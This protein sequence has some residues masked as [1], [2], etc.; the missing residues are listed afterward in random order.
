VD[1]NGLGLC[2]GFERPCIY[3]SELVQRPESDGSTSYAVELYRPYPA[4]GDPD[5][6]QLAIEDPNETVDV[7]SFT[8]T[9]DFWVYW[10]N[11]RASPVFS[12]TGKVH[13]RRPVVHNSITTMVTVDSVNVPGGAW[14]SYQRDINTHRCMNRKWT[15]AAASTVGAANTYSSGTKPIQAHPANIDFTNVG[16]IGKVFSESAYPPNG[17][18]YSTDIDEEEE[19]RIDLSDPNYQRLFNYLTVF[20][21]SNDGIDNDG[22]GLTDEADPN[23]PQETPEFKIPGRININTAPWYIIAQL[24][25]VSQRTG[26]PNDYSLA[27]AIAAYRDK[28]DL[29]G[30]GG[31][32]YRLRPGGPGFRCTGELNNVV[33]GPDPYRIDYYALDGADQIQL[34][35]LTGADGAA[36]DFE[37]RDLI[38]A[39]ISNLVTARSD[40]FTAYILVRIGTDGP[41]RRMIA[42]LDRSNVY[43]SAGKVNVVALHPVPDPR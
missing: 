25:W 1:V 31:P 5:G 20:D 26:R 37:E 38:F 34:P 35:D 13:L 18:G 29:T 4:G 3:I 19:V 10:W 17:I 32:D 39:R 21:P 12:G 8:R 15:P 33:L 30:E 27:K 9:G 16:E 40:V 7:N 24:P 28:A 36:D 41:Q 22:D 11:N 14:S 43:S 23:R 6:W 42:I 2:Y